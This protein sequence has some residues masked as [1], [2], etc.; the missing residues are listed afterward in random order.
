MIKSSNQIL[1]KAALKG[2]LITVNKLKPPFLNKTK[3]TNKFYPL[4]A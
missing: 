1:L 3:I 2:A 4:L